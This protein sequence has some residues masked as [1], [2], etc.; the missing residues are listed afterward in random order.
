MMSLA[1]EDSGLWAELAKAI[2]P[3]GSLDSIVQANL[4]E[5]I[6]IHWMG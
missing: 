1:T 4:P 2:V 6:H 5:L 3:S